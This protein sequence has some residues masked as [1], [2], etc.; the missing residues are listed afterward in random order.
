M[1]RAS[2]WANHSA[3]S[4]GSC[5]GFQ[6]FME[7]PVLTRRPTM[8]DPERHLLEGRVLL[9]APTARDAVATR[10]ILAS[11]GVTCFA[12]KDMGEVCRE[13]G[14]GVGA[15]LLPQEAILADPSACLL[16]V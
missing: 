11:A 10:N 12:C 9:L 2:M 4:T 15:A 14:R 6:P 16:R 5:P 1:T 3:T 8:I 13:M 7:T